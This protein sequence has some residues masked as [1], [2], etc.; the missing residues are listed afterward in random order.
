MAYAKA[1]MFKRALEMSSVWYQ[2]IEKLK[3]KIVAKVLTGSK[4]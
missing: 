1:D 4:L 2:N 3:G